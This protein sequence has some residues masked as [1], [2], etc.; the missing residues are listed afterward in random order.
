MN[1]ATASEQTPLGTPGNAP[2]DRP[3]LMNP[4][5]RERLL[6]LIAALGRRFPTMRFGQLVCMVASGARGPAP[7][8]IYDAED[9]EMI[10]AIENQMAF[11]RDNP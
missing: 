7:E 1:P 9:E 2:Q 8:S 5:T 6:E 11:L 4:A 3:D 10:A